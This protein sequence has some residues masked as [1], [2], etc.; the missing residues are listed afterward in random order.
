MPSDAVYG[1]KKGN[2]ELLDLG[3]VDKRL[4]LDEREF[5]QAPAVLR[6]DASI[7]SRV[8]RDAWDGLEVLATLTKHSPTRATGAHISII[9]HI[10]ADEPR[11]ALEGKTGHTW[12]LERRE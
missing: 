5:Y 1:M 7:L 8:V 2:E 6:R 10:T 9:S 3:V 11:E 12:M 4:L